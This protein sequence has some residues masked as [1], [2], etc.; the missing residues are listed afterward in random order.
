MWRTQSTPLLID[1]PNDV[2]FIKLDRIEEYEKALVEGPWMIGGNCL[3]VQRWRPNF[4]TERE[5]IS[6]LLVWIRFSILPIEY[7]TEKCLRR[8]RD[9]IKKVINIDVTM[10]VVSREKFARVFVEV[11]LN[12]VLMSSYMLRGEV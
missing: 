11:E 10:L 5:K 2:Y 1:L 9:E 12:K 3:H 4:R 6:I 7:C 8:A